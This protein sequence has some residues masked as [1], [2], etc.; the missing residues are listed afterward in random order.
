MK[1]ASE[2]MCRLVGIAARGFVHT[3][4]VT[5]LVAVTVG[6]VK[7]ASSSCL[8]TLIVQV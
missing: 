5:F 6:S 8:A 4:R 1:K 7:L 3:T 2:E